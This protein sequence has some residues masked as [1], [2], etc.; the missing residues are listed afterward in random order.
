[1]NKK[2]IIVKKDD[3]TVVIKN[4]YSTKELNLYFNNSIEIS[5]TSLFDLLDFKAND[6]YTISN[7]VNEDIFKKHYAQFKEIL[8]FLQ[9]L[10]DGINEIEIDGLTKLLNN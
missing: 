10:I 5:A 6:K 8:T 4:D 1:M 7:E 3:S 2:I 9:D